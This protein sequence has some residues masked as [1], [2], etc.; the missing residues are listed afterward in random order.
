MTKAGKLVR[1]VDP[2]S[3]VLSLV[4]PADWGTL[5]YPDRVLLPDYTAAG[6]FTS[7]AESMQRLQVPR[8]GWHELR[9][10]ARRS[11]GASLSE[12]T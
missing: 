3:R 8:R 4:P 1:R 12:D 9:D 6:A 5:A 10:P 2:G 11:D 7:Y